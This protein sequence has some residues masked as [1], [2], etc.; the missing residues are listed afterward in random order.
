MKQLPLVLVCVMLSSCEL[1][2]FAKDPEVQELAKAAGKAGADA[3]AEFSSGNWEAA[4]A[5]GAAAVGITIAIIRKW[6][7]SVNKR[8][9]AA[10]E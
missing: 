9:G 8:K 1:V 4:G 3:A 6:P 7:G 2:E 5:A 10:P